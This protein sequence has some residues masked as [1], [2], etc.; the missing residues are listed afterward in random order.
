EV[1][2]GTSRGTVPDAPRGS[3]GFGF[4]PVFVPEGEVRTFA[5]MDVAEKEAHSHRGRALA[6]LRERL[7]L[8]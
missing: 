1:M 4:D 8:L 3:K 2:V 5:E 7:S 6:R